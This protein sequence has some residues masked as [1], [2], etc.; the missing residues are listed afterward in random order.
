M[1]DARLERALEEL[2]TRRRFLGRAGSAG[3]ALS[4]LSACGGVE[5]E[6]EKTAKERPKAAAVNHPKT[7]IGDW[8][9]ANWPLYVD[10]AVIKDFNKRFGGKCKYVEEI[11]DNNEFFGKVRQQL[12][13]K[14]PIGR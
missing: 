14:Q 11:N 7:E 10:K 1:H 9:F 4:L 6:A 2:L 13:R 3:L 12:Q 8:T 5:G